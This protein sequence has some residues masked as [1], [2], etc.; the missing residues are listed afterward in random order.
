MAQTAHITTAQ[1][2]GII[3]GGVELGYTRTQFA[4]VGRTGDWSLLIEDG[5]IGGWLASTREPTKDRTFKTLDAV[6]STVRELCKSAGVEP[7]A[8]L[9]M[10][11]VG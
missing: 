10:R 3:S 9:H 7:R 2:V 8:S 6:Y 5:E 11:I 4:A 1:A